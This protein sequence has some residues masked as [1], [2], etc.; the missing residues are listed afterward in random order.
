MNQ[1]QMPVVTGLKDY[2]HK[3][4]YSFHVPGHKD[5]RIVPEEMQRC[6][7]ELMRL[8]ATEVANLDDLYHPSGILR[9]GEALLSEYYQTEASYFLVN[10]ST[11]GNLTMIMATVQPGD[12]VLVQRDSHKSVFNGLRLAGA[13]PVLLAPA[14][15]PQTGFGHAVSEQALDEALCR[16]PDARAL[17]LTYPNYYGMAGRIRSLIAK[18]HAHD[19]VVLVDEAHGPHFHLGAPMPP[20]ALDQGADIVVHSAHKMLPALTMGAWLHCKGGRVQP[21]KIAAIREML[22]TSSPSYPIM[23]SLDL[24]RWFIAGLSSKRIAAICQKREAFVQQLDTIP[25]ITVLK[26]TDSFQ[27]DPFKLTLCLD[28][29]ESGYMW[30]DRLI[31][32]GIY[33]ELADPRHVLLVLGLTD[34]ETYSDAFDRIRSSLSGFHRRTE[35]A[36]ETHIPVFPLVQALGRSIQEMAN[37]SI[38]IID[39]AEA[40]GKLAAESIIPYPPGIPLIL[41]GEVISAGQIRSAGALLAAGAVF[42]NTWIKHYKMMIYSSGD[43]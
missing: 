35:K 14:I 13:V 37:D 3:Q 22:Q 20:S 34:K 30:Q 17:I 21:A 19:L 23:A 32:A 8:D 24:A 11:V 33:P 12:R 43:A 16:F 6:F 5:G 41:Q 28:Y 2:M 36:G 4:R 9:D 7:R 15:D 18:A 31:E 40:E 29:R 38:E 42:Q 10:G 39:L 27:I 25:G 1:Q 26:S